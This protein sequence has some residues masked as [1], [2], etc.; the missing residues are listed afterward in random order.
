MDLRRHDASQRGWPGDLAIL[1]VLAGAGFLGA[2]PDLGRAIAPFP[3]RHAH[4][5][6]ICQR[7]LL[8]FSGWGRWCEGQAG[9]GEAAVDEVGPEL[10]SSRS[11]ALR[12]G[13]CQD[14]P[15]RS[16]SRHTVATDRLT[17]RRRRITF[18]TR[19]EAGVR[20]RSRAPTGP[21][22]VPFEHGELVIGHGRGVRRTR[23]AQGLHAALVPGAAPAFH[24]SHAHPR[25]GAFQPGRPKL[26]Q[27]PPS[28]R[29]APA[30]YARGAGR[31][32]RR[33]GTPPRC[34]RLH[35][36]ARHRKPLHH[37]PRLRPGRRQG[38]GRPPPRRMP[39]Q[40]MT[41]VSGDS[42]RRRHR[43]SIGSDQGP[44]SNEA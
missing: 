41:T 20:Q 34:R 11:S 22:R 12:A 23:R 4:C 31:L 13:A 28:R 30:R 2:L 44:A 3:A 18:W 43:W 1:Q 5:G 10:D 7:Q 40:G 33:S 32:R 42:D 17:R 25:L 15:C 39:Q 37:R 35:A 8:R 26:S 6:A 14:Q 16:S 29:A 21:C 24:R 9:G 19:S 27:V 38:H 36:S